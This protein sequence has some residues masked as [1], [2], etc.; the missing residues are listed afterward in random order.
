M[1]FKQE[2]NGKKNQGTR[3]GFTPPNNHTRDP[4]RS[5]DFAIQQIIEAMI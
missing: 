1:V 5:T 3:G 2:R 4:T